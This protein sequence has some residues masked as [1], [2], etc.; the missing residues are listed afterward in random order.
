MLKYDFLFTY[1]ILDNPKHP[2]QTSY[3]ASVVLLVH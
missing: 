3:P 2:I 1:T